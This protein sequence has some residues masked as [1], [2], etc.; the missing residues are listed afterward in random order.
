MRTDMAA[1]REYLNSEDTEP[2]GGCECHYNGRSRHCTTFAYSH[3]ENPWVF[4]P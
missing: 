1:A 2:N 3:S 4:G